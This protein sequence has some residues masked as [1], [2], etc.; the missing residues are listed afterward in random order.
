MFHFCLQTHFYITEK[1]KS[2]GN[3]VI[4][5]KKKIWCNIKKIGIHSTGVGWM[6]G[7]MDGWT[8]ALF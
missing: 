6:D 8:S 1:N 4:F 5:Y 3:V 7:W 2:L